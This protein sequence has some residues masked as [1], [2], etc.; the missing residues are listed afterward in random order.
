MSST[1]KS[2]PTAH[3]TP[4]QVPPSN[5]VD[6][7]KSSA[8]KELSNP[9]EKTAN[10]PARLGF[11]L[12][13][14]VV[15]VLPIA[16]GLG[17]ARLKASALHS[18]S[19]LEQSSESSDNDQLAANQI[20]DRRIGDRDFIERRYEVALRSYQSLGSQHPAR[21]P[22]EV[23]YRIALCQE[24]LGL[25]DEA[26][27]GMR[28]VAATADASVLRT[29]A[30]FGQAR[31]WFR[32]NNAD[33]AL[34]LLRSLELHSAADRQ[35]PRSLSQDIAFLIPLALAQKVVMAAGHDSAYPVSQLLTWS[36]DSALS[37]AD[38]SHT[39][40]STDI[41]HE[42]SNRPSPGALVQCRL[43]RP[44]NDATNGFH[45][46]DWKIDC[47]CEGRT[48][49]TVVQRIADE[50]GWTLDWSELKDDLA[51]S[52][53]VS[54]DVEKRSIWS[55]MT[56]LAS[57]L[58]ATWSFTDG[59][60]VITRS[61]LEGARMRQMIMST[62]QSLESCMPNHRFV[63]HGRFAMAQLT[64]SQ[65]DLQRAATMFASLT[66]RQ[67][68]LLAVRAAYN[69][70]YNYYR[71][72][73]FSHAC[74]QLR[75]VVDGAPEQS[76]HA[77]ALILL[78]RLLM[79]RG[80]VQDAIFQL[81][82]ATDSR[83]LPNEQARAAVLLGMAY[84]AQEKYQDAAESVFTH[85]LQLDEPG[86]RYAASFVT[87]YSR[88]HSVSG[89]MKEREATFL[90]RALVAVRNDSEWLGQAGEFLIGRAYIELG[91][92]DVM[93]DLYSH[94]LNEGVT[95]YIEAEM[96]Y[97]LAGY[98]M[99]N[100]QL[101]MAAQL[102]HKL[103]EGPANRWKN[104]ARLK[105]A[106]VALVQGNSKVALELCRQAQPDESISRGEILKVMGRA[107]EQL[108]EDA[109]AARCYAGQPPTP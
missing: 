44:P 68:S 9:Q 106:E 108:G 63:Q 85:K 73:D 32:L 22:A 2:S 21:L 104:R 35:L 88:W 14:T 100:G 55:L 7:T 53:T 36:F 77:E 94:R 109:N 8:S 101:E 107:F 56:T 25:W 103:A 69:A 76:I 99:A 47:L 59:R 61:D 65:G 15:T 95:E 41:D 24:A 102:W 26:L 29:A 19:V 64:Q 34:S 96:T 10:S 39:V 45:I 23:Q 105:S 5:S 72:G 49:E 84:L 3:S 42:L 79:D 43:H 74:T 57:E 89:Q 82:R 30:G 75:F 90:Y 93:A 60:L 62:L 38:E 11:S 54:I 71:L 46:E 81:R 20:S 87:A 13:L 31:I 4:A 40:E 37:W 18:P 80:E 58:R 67:S 98:Q 66:G 86:V 52:Q 50:G 27:A 78:G 12:A 70:A 48:I 1:A 33:Q 28:S 16:F 6:S 51:L 83:C 97:S 17:S 92:D 91:F